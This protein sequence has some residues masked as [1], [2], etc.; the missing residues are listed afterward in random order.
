MLARPL[1]LIVDDHIEMARVLAEELADAG[2]E[3]KV[4]QDGSEALASARD[5]IPDVVLTDLR[6]EKMDGFDI[7]N[8]IKALDASVPVLIMTAFGAIDSAVE[9]I[10]RGAYHY[11]TKPFQLQEVL[12]YVERALADRRLRDEH[13]ALKKMAVER[14]GFGVMVGRSS[15]MRTLYDLIERAAPSPAPVLVCGESGTGKELVARALHF[16]GPRRDGPFVAVNCSALPETLL[17]S[18]LF[19]HTRGAFTGAASARR[20]LFVEAD[21]GTLFL[22]E[23]GDMPATLQAKLLRV[24]E[25]GEVR[26]IGSDAVRRADVRVIAATHRDLEKQVRTAVFRA[27]LFY[28]L[29]VI[30]LL[31]PPLRSRAEDIPLLVEKFLVRA[32]ERNPNAKAISLSP[33]AIAHLA[34]RP[35]PGNV[36]ELENYIERLLIMSTKEALEARDLDIPAPLP[37]TDLP[38]LVSACEQIVTLRQLE[39]EYIGWVISHCGGN[40]TRAAEL[41]GIDVSTIYRRDRD[42]GVLR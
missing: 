5:R 30:T 41:L 24:I 23:I 16:E 36:R 21:G 35:W 13:R 33:E 37:A 27:D 7:L 10:K 15:V 6:M 38:P 14:A 12:V 39:D 9:A 22:D 34:T 3:T 1:V 26:A 19:G 18:E 20:G 32:R 11:L 28:R 40:K 25:T 17:E 42:R 8:A 2:Y 29:N 4:A 31:V